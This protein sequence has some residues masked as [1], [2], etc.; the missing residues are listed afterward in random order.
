VTLS[1]DVRYGDKSTCKD[2]FRLLEV[3]VAVVEGGVFFV[4]GDLASPIA[5]LTRLLRPVGHLILALITILLA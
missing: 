1:S 5:A 2:R 4:E 3:G